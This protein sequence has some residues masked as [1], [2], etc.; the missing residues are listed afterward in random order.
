MK[1]IFHKVNIFNLK[2]LKTKKIKNVKHKI[3]EIT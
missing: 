1:V 3:Y 2:I